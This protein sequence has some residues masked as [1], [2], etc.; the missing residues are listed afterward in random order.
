ML[1]ALAGGYGAPALRRRAA[2]GAI[3]QPGV[4]GLVAHFT[5]HYTY[6]DFLLLSDPSCDTHVWLISSDAQ[7]AGNSP[8]LH[9]DQQAGFCKIP[10]HLDQHG[11]E[12]QEQDCERPSCIADALE[13][14]LKLTLAAAALPGAAGNAAVAFR[15]L[16]VRGA[17]RLQAPAVLAA[18]TGAAQGV[19]SP[20]G[21][22]C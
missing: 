9:Q 11:T 3:K 5:R 10:R 14:A 4:A 2:G 12:L 20:Q 6:G 21:A 18:L 17:A 19:L 15:A 16:C 22:L 13:G 7:L 8:A 1:V